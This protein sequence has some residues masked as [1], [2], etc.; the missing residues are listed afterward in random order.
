LYLN[1]HSHQSTAVTA[2]VIRNCYEN[3]EQPEPGNWYSLGL[4]PWHI[5]ESAWEKEFAL[6]EKYSRLPQ[7]LAIGEC[8]LD[9]VCGTNFEL[10]QQVFVQHIQLAN[11]LQ[12]PLIIHCVKAIEETIHLLSAEK[13]KMPVIFHGFVKSKEAALQLVQ[14]GYYLSFGQALQHKKTGRY[15]HLSL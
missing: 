5:N 7:V 11:S 14:K 6:V 3:F 1:I 4:H 9:K 15:W 13:N 8:G 12:K 2:G 10:Q